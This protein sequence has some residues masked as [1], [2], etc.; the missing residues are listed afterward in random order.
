MMDAGSI[1]SAFCAACALELAALKPGNVHVHAPGH[2]MTEADFRRSAEAAAAPLCRPGMTLGRRVLDAVTAT[3]AAVGQNTNLGILLLC[4]PL[5]MAAEAAA[6]A[7]GNL[8]DALRTVLAAAGTDDA[9]A[10]F[11]AIVLAAP[12]GLGDAPDHDVRQRAT[13][14]LRAAMAAAAP[15]DSIARQYVSDFTDVFATG[16][17]TYAAALARGRTAPWAAVVVYLEFLVL[18]PDSHAQR[19]HGA[20]IAAE[21]QREALAWRERLAAADDPAS[22]LQDLLTWDAALKRRGLNPGTSADLTV[23]SIFAWTL[24]GDLRRAALDG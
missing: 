5:A 2:G 15:R 23:A 4:A 21:L 10:V 18:L 9:D 20:V 22:L 11:R 12:G 19:K 24:C 17:A 6:D 3:R 8:R 13:V 7:G 1:A 16:C 14:P